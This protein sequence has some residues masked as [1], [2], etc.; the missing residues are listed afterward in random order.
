MY[1]EAERLDVPVATHGAP[2]T[3]LGLNSFSQF[4]KTIAPSIR[5]RR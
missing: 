1:E 3:N 2:S 5:S 4:A